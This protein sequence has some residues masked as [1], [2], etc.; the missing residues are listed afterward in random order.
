[1]AATL[2]PQE[3]W[4]LLAVIPKR[5]LCVG[6]SRGGSQASFFGSFA[7]PGEEGAVETLQ[8]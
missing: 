5:S 3:V 6:T 1:M 2:W 4:V 8:L 7:S